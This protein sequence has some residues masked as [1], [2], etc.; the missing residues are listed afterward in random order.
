MNCLHIQPKKQPKL[1][2]GSGK[3]TFRTEGTVDME[4]MPGN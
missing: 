4:G 1:I 2:P 3:L